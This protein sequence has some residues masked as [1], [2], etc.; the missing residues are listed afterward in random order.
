MMHV[1]TPKSHFSPHLQEL[2]AILARGVVRLRRHTA[3][4]LARDSAQGPDQGES[5]LHFPHYQSGH[6]N[7][8]KR[9]LA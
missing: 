7:P 3:E 5:S 6:A 4:N 9:R 8:A 1:N 2:C